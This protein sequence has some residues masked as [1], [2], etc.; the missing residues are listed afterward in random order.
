MNVIRLI[1]GRVALFFCA[2]LCASPLLAS[3]RVALMIGNSDYASPDMSLRNPGNDV[4]ALS[5]ALKELGFTVIQALNQN[6]AAMER[7]VDQFGIAAQGA[8]MAVFFYAGHGVQI[9]GANYL[10]GTDFQG[11]D[12]GSLQRSSMTLD[13]VRDVMA[14]AGPD[15]GILLLDACRNNPFSDSGL[16]EQGLVRMRGG[17]GLLIAYATDPG[18]VAYDGEGQNSVFTSGLL[19]HISTPDLDVRLMLGRVRQQ[20]VLETEGRQIPWV[21]E[22]V[23]D[24]HSFAPGLPGSTPQD[25]I[26][27]DLEHWRQIASSSDKR[28]FE[29]YLQTFPDGLFASFAHEKLSGLDGATPLIAAPIPTTMTEADPEQLASALMALGHLTDPLTRD[30]GP[31]LDRYRQGLPMPENASAAQLFEDAA[32]VSVFLAATT[33]QRLRTDIVALRSVERTLTIAE[34]ALRQIEDIARSDDSALPVLQQARN[35][36][37]DI[38]R[39]RGIILR[40]LDQ[41]RSYYDEVLRRAVVFFP[42]DINISIVSAASESRDLNFADAQ[43]RRDAALFLR[44]VSQADDSRKG[45]YQWL[46]DFIPPE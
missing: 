11:S 38:Y 30:L 4:S 3:D 42:P 14:K 2:V 10:I 8:E 32:Q 1:A 9:G 36:I 13:R 16:V 22:S 29:T 31:A 45:S 12:L 23:L 40:R 21:E 35:D 41:S 5:D 24:E 37:Y 20:V 39:S 6:A 19:D 43:L 15:V 44:H 7:A 46:A 33:M 28:A 17:A 18:N 34:D 27:A 26:A 25:D